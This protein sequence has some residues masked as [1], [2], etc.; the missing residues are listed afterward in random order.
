MM[1]R[2]DRVLS[3]ALA[4]TALFTAFAA[5][6]ATTGSTGGGQPINNMQPATTVGYIVAMQGVFPSSSGPAVTGTILGEVRRFAGNFA[7]AGWAFC[8]GQLL[9]I[10]SN[11]A[12]F[13]LIGTTYGGD[14]HTTFALPDL[15]GRTPIHAG[16]G[17]GLAN[18]PM[19]R[20]AAR[21]PSR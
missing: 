9:P 5:R 6:A 18:H 10:A 16:Q 4:G 8:D 12:I 11:T 1:M 2:A 3:I 20:A 13:S 17:P 15:R 14:G 21:R 19:E 7:P